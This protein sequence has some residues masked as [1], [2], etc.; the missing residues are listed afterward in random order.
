MNKVAAAIF[1]QFGG[2]LALKMIGGTCGYGETKINVA[3]KAKA[4]NKSNRVV[5][6]LA[7]DDTYTVEFWNCRGVN[8]NK[9]ER[10]DGIYADQLRPTFESKTGLYLSM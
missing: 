2:F 7:G 6:T 9:I 8:M 4:K 3:F 5:I 1:S 10:L